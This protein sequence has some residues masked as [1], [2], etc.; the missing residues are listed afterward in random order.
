MLSLISRIFLRTA[1]VLAGLSFVACTNSQIIEPEPEPASP[2]PWVEVVLP[3]DP[4]PSTLVSIAFQGTRGLALGSSASTADYEYLLETTGSDWHARYLPVISSDKVLDVSMNEYGRAVIVGSG[5]ENSVST[6]LVLV[7]GAGWQRAALPEVSGPWSQVSIA[8][9]GQPQQKGLVDVACGFDDG[10]VGSD[11]SPY[12]VVLFDEGAGW[13]LINGPGCGACIDYE[14]RAVAFDEH[15][16]VLLGGSYHRFGGNNPGDN[17]T[18]LA[19]YDPTYRHWTSIDL[20]ESSTLNRINDILVT[21]TGDIYLA[22]G[23]YD[24]ALVHLSAAG[25]AEIEWSS[26]TASIVHLAEA[27]TGYVY[28]VGGQQYREPSPP[29]LTVPLPP[30]LRRPVSPPS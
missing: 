1:L 12:S 25:V 7:E 10:A 23:K 19:H 22:C 20:P 15:G 13:K 9:T 14:F 26:Q 18:F 17:E 24:A 8:L 30:M 5:V 21:G 11:T 4:P 29:Y 16:K 3:G 27:S 28:A 2:S 6:P